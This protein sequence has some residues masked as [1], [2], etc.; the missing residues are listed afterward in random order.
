MNARV[1]ELSDE[2]SELYVENQ[3]LK[4]EV[5]LYRKEAAKAMPN[6]SKLSLADDDNQ[7][8][9]TS[10]GPMENDPE[11][12]FVSSGNGIYASNPTVS[13]FQLHNKT[14]PLCCSLQSN[15]DALLA[16]GGA[17][18]YI[19]ICP[20]GLALA[21]KLGAAEET[22]QNACRV[23]CSSGAPVICIGFAHSRSLPILVAGCMDGSVH[24]IAFGNNI[25]NNNNSSSSSIGAMSL[26]PTSG[27]IKQTKYIKCI[28]WSQQ[29]QQFS[30]SPNNNNNIVA[31]ASA[32]GTIIL[33]RILNY[34]ETK[35]MNKD[36]ESWKTKILQTLHLS[37]PIESM[38]FLEH[39]SSKLMLCCYVRGTSY[40]SYFDVE[41]DCKLIKYS[42][43]TGGQTGGFEDHVSFAIMDLKLSPNG[44]FLAAATDA[45]RNI[46]LEVGSSK[47]IRNLYGHKNDDYSQP[48]IGWSHNGQYL[49]GTTQDDTS[50]CVWDIASSKIVKRL[51]GHSG[52][53]RDLFCSIWSDTMV[54]AS[55]DKS[56]KIWLLNEEGG[57]SR[58]EDGEVE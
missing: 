44:K 11:D 6:L 32:D 39:T 40:L 14:N 43:N 31:I 7:Q 49:F 28:S 27:P 15:T 20:W 5:E 24:F 54:T 47:Q 51:S 30:T 12:I 33:L 48:K 23:R 53:I 56:I 35:L 52:Q 37:G 4:A 2:C 34:D 19:T 8:N 29:Q 21:P 58:M 46:I 42:L 36:E 9:T 1:K 55:Y 57:G 13:L 18:G 16:T 38:C 50:I 26:I 10:Y 25:P 41:N 45:S 22:V 3:A 17:D